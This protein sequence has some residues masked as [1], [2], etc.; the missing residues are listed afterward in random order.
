MLIRSNQLTLNESTTILDSGVYLTEAEAALNP[1]A[2]PVLENQRLDICTVS[3]NDIQR[4]CEDYGCYNEDALHAIA[5]ASNVD[6]D[7]IAVAID[8]SDII[9]DPSIVNEFSQYVV[10]PLSENSLAYIFCETSLENFIDTEDPFYLNFLESFNNEDGLCYLIEALLPGTNIDEKDLKNR[11]QKMA[12]YYNSLMGSNGKKYTTDDVAGQGMGANLGAKYKNS[13]H[14]YRNQAARLRK[15]L[16]KAK[17]KD[18]KERIKGM[19]SNVQDKIKNA[20]KENNKMDNYYDSLKPGKTKT[21]TGKTGNPQVDKAIADA[22][23]SNDPGFI[24]KKVAALRNFYK[25]FLDQANKEKDQ[26]KISW[27]KNIARVILNVIDKLL[28]KI[29]GNNGTENK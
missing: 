19:I 14:M 23:N 22:Q 21:G 12:D 5:E 28:A 7:H 13:L 27:Y 4:V 18:S 25:K 29:Q 16:K 15:L 3:Y 26:N 8:E 11:D 17:D 2:V 24:S 10:K 9:L 6:I 1:V 20:N